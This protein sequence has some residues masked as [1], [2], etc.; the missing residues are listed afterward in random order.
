MKQHKKKYSKIILLLACCMSFVIPLMAD[1]SHAE[2]S[3]DKVTIMEPITVTANKVEEDVQEIPQSITVMDEIEL[4]K[5]GITLIPELVR[6]IPNMY[7]AEGGYGNAVSFRGLIPS[8]FTNCN[9]VVIYI[10]GIPLVSRYGY[11]ASLA[12][13]ER[14][15]V[16]RGPQG[17]LYGK[18]AIGGVINVVTKQPGNEWHGMAG[19]EYG[20]NNYMQGIFNLNG[21]LKKDV[22]FMGVNGL[23]QKDDGWIE[24]TNPGLD[25]TGNESE[26]R[27]LSGYLLY[28]P[29]DRF[30]ARLTLSY[31]FDDDAWFSS[32]ALPPGADISDFSR[33]A[34]EKVDFDYP[35]E[36]NID[37]FSQSLYLSYA[38]DAMT[39]TS[40]TTHTSMDI[41]GDYDADLMSGTI[42]D[43]LK[44]YNHSESDSYTQEL[45]LAGNNTAGI[46]WV[47][48][49][50]YETE[51]YDPGPYGMEYPYYDSSGTFYGVF[52]YN[53]E[54][55]TNSETYAAFAQIMVPFGDR[56]EMTLGARYQ[57]IEK[58]IAENMYFVSV[59]TTGS[60]M[61][62]YSA[63]KDW[64]VFLPKAALSYHLTDNWNTYVSYSQGYMPGGF[65]Y[66][67]ESGT[68]DDNSFEPQKSA[69]YEVGI[70]GRTDRFRMTAALFYM[71][72]EDVHV[73][74]AD[75]VTYYTDNAEKGHSQGI[76]LEL[77][78]QLTDTIELTGALGLI[79]AEYDTYDAGEGGSFDGQDIQSTPAYT[80]N[81]AV[82]YAH[83]CG[84]YA[85]VDMRGAGD[86]AYYDNAGNYFVEGDAYMIYN[87]KIGYL[88][89]NWDFYVY[90]KNL[91]D[92][93]Y[94]NDYYTTSLL[95]QAYFGDPLTVGA[96]IRYHF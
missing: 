88:T 73:F 49:L 37:N 81:A 62:S 82:N 13:V 8:M 35:T 72:I 61:Y 94:I 2:E 64:D 6:E 21:P 83:P 4:K 53:S 7:I 44:K 80:L 20:S 12:N 9:P 29:N 90:G 16:L 18:D 91:S 58:D 25:S 85:R 17:T 23:F 60:P 33:D 48:G 67:A 15:E 43:G 50:Y 76:E 93:E 32:Y 24:N 3:K 77:A 95:T 41:E 89:G 55:Q 87:A 26:D 39:L 57:H 69:N 27:R 65:N 84:F 40:T 47:G 36:V 31:S 30:T 86:T 54:S 34:A 28:T 22:L 74:K 46:R 5:R 51:D 59:G 38:F 14:I 45:R 63:D 71:D 42:F 75:G 10:D 92:E 19:A 96:G 1:V 66:F 79:E 68:A 78:Y 56:F 11:D 70:K 52:D